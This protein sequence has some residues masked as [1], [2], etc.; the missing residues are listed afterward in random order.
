M[1]PESLLWRKILVSASG[2]LYWGGVLVLARRVRKQ[3]GRSP[4]LKPRGS[5]EKALW[6]GWFLV[7]AA[8]IGQPFFLGR[9]P[10]T[11]PLASWL[12][13]PVSLAGLILLTG[14]YAATLWSYGAMGN[15]WRIGVNAKEKT[16][17]VRHGPYRWIRHPIYGFQVV[18]LAGAALLLPTPLSLVILLFHLGCVYIK[19]TDEERYLCR[20]HGDDYRQ[21]QACTGRLFPKILRK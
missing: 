19:A 11:T 2:L 15:T 20:A 12:L 18:M 4:N 9:T 3:I 10:I 1:S 8:W 21:Y 5:R 14:G 13:A 16:T 7:I 6:F 17:L